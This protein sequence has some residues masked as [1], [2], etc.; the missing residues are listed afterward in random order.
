MANLEK[1]KKQAVRPMMGHYN[2]DP[3]YSKGSER[4]HRDRT[5]LNYCIGIREG[6]VGQVTA[7]AGSEEVLRRAESV[8]KASGKAIRKDAVLMAD[9]CVTLPQ[10]VREG[11]ERK[12]FCI[13]YAW[14]AKKVGQEN[15]LGGW[16]HMDESR[17]HMH[18]AFTPIKDGRF[19][20]KQLCPRSFYQ[21]LHVELSEY[22]ER[23]LGYPVE[24]LLD[25]ERE[26]DK[27]LSG[28][29]QKD[30]IQAKETIRT[31][32]EQAR[33]ERATLDELRE[34]VEQVNDEIVLAELDMPDVEG[35]WEEVKR[36][37]EKVKR[38][39][40]ERARVER[41]TATLKAESA[42]LK[43]ESARLQEL[44]SKLAAQAETLGRDIRELLS[45]AWEYLARAWNEKGPW[46]EERDA[47]EIGDALS[48]AADDLGL[49]R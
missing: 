48:R 27:Q 9:L 11:D 41:E 14:L 37:E 47:P 6:R 45:R 5:H 34:Q 44:V 24:I 17:P 23:R 31:A 7:P 33:K 18:A 26:A 19:S 28:L 25:P 16:V 10:N 3:S 49:E 12:F 43:A 29:S 4:I 21:G 8:S 32:Q 46:R 42:E 40:A 36:A 1:F 20:F 2:R 39:E 13:A 22:I 35:A 15:M 30:Y 38:A